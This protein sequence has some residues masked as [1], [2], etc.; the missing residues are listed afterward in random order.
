MYDTWGYHNASILEQH[1]FYSNPQEYFTNLFHSSYESGYGRLFDST[2]SYW[3]DLKANIF[4]KLLSVFDFFSFGNYYINVIFYCFITLTGPVM[5][6]RIMFDI[7]PQKKMLL[8]VACFLVP[9]FLYWTSGIHKDGI[10]YTAICII[11]YHLYFGLKEGKISLRRWA[12]LLTGAL[13]LLAMRNYILVVLAPALLAWYL[14]KRFP[15]QLKTIFAATYLTGA[16]LF[17]SLKYISPS[18]DF[19]AAVAN[20]QEA[21]MKLEGGSG[22]RVRPLTPT[23]KGFIQNAPQ[24]IINS[25]LRPFPSDIKHMLS[26][27]VALENGIFIVLILFNIFYHTKTPVREKAFIWFCIF[28]SCSIL[29]TIGYTV[30]FQGAIVRYR[31]III[32]FL[33]TPLLAG[34][35]WERIK[36]QIIK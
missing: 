23:V 36:K 10:T 19:P 13:I 29:M 11:L 27:G 32:P 25:T 16:I 31:S 1:L 26:L 12:Y 6:F 14:S 9:S 35:D 20:K 34:I 2:N 18:L 22:I 28:F 17:F 7:Y 8:L 33:I 15:G 24:A 30:N 4:I 21:F 5:T 3:N